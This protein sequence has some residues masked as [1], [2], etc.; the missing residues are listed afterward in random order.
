MFR[1]VL[2]AVVI[3]VPATGLGQ[4]P[5]NACIV[6]L[7]AVDESFDRTHA[8]LSEANANGDLPRKCAAVAGHIEALAKGVE[9][10]QRCIPAGPD[11]DE[12]VAS[13]AANLD[14]FREIHTGLKCAGALVP[15]HFTPLPA[16]WGAR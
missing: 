13:L 1:A 7:N 14:S 6:E 8:A 3:L 12:N 9:V 16:S 2:A 10:Y 15:A 5:S 11:R 4:V